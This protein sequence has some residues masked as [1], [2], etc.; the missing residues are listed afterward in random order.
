M[1]MLYSNGDGCCLYAKVNCYFIPYC[2]S[3]LVLHKETLSAS[4]KGSHFH[5][6]RI[7]KVSSHSRS[8]AEHS[9]WKCVKIGA[10]W[11]FRCTHTIHN[12]HENFFHQKV[13]W[14]IF[15]N[16]CAR[17]RDQDAE[18]RDAKAEMPKPRCLGRDTKANMLRLRC[19]D[20]VLRRSAKP[21]CLD[22]VQSKGAMPK[23]HAKVP[24]ESAKSFSF[25]RRAKQMKM[26]E[27]RSY[28]SF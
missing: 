7:R 12:G 14:Q 20:K 13:P 18:A 21:K 25:S 5:R 11:A 6:S 22:K 4:S 1:S 26:C 3:R 27:N 23:C 24:S 17:C 15:Q 8:P 28:L 19:Q 16:K 10:T 9:K 2:S